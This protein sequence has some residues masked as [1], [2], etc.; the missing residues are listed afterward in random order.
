[1]LIAQITDPH[2]KALGH[3]AYKRVSTEKNLKRC[4]EHVMALSTRPD[5]VLM[6][7]DLTDF[8]RP[9]EYELLRTLIAPLNMPVFVIPGNH[10]TREGL[11]KAFGDHH[12][13]PGKGE[14]IHYVID[15]FPLRLIGLDTTIPGRPEGI[16]CEQ[17]LAWLDKQLSEKPDTPTALFMHHPPVVTGINH[18][19][20]QNC[21]NAE[22]L[23]ELIERHKQVFHVLCGHLHRP[24]HTQWHGVTVTI[25]PSASHYVAL[26][27]HADAPAQFNLEPPAVQLHQWRENSAL[28]SHLS[29]IGVFD[30]PHPFYDENGKLID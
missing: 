12:Y 24:V 10:D 25:A 29:F 26:E 6:T 14:F 8:G 15:E 17:R 22:A 2:I 16:M 20:V 28:I 3:L 4:V 23:G 11:R 13:L 7:G 1:M 27:L 18:M 5:I 21:G 19:D 9:A 30:G